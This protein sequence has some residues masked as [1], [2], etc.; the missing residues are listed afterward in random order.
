MASVGKRETIVSR[1]LEPPSALSSGFEWGTR[2][3]TIGMEFALPALL[4]FG[5]DRGLGTSPWCTVLGAFLGLGIGM[6]HVLRL[7]QE[8]ARPTRELRPSSLPPTGVEPPDTSDQEP[9]EADIRN[10]RGS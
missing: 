7:P 9:G 3:T 6:A 8:L 2:V 5:L 10:G 4:G 1:K